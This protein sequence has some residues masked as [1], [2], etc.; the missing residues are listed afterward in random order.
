[1]MAYLTLQG[2]AIV[3]LADLG[4]ATAANDVTVVRSVFQAAGYWK[5]PPAFETA[6]TGGE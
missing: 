2:L 5:G 1:M 3:M 6:H 4:F